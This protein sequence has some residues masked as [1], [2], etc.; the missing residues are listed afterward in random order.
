MWINSGRLRPSE[1]HGVFHWKSIIPPTP[2]HFGESAR[3]IQLPSRTIRASNLEKN[4][5]GPL[6][7]CLFESGIE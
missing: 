1:Y 5:F 3:F 4:L 7:F 6:P 2:A